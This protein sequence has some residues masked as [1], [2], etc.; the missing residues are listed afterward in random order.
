MREIVH[1]VGTNGND[2]VFSDLDL[3]SG[4]ARF[5][6]NANDV[7]GIASGFLSGL[8]E[9]SGAYLAFGGLRGLTNEQYQDQLI[10]VPGP[11][12]LVALA[13][14]GLTRRRRRR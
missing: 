10:V 13:G 9:G 8:G 5:S 4:M 11:A 12:G 3:G 7:L 14:L 6:T 1:E 2:F